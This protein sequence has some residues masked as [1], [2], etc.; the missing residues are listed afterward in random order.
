MHTIC[1]K[2]TLH[3][4]NYAHHIFHSLLHA[5]T[6]YMQYMSYYIIPQNTMHMHVY[7]TCTHQVYPRRPGRFVS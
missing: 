5:C 2:L 7:Y 3:T 4:H 1:I 6:S